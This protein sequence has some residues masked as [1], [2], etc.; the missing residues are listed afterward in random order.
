M[1]SSNEVHSSLGGTAW[2]YLWVVG[3]DFLRTQ[4]AS[5][6]FQRLTL[7]YLDLT[8]FHISL[9]CLWII[10]SIQVPLL[11]FSFPS[12]LW[13]DSRRHVPLPDPYAS[14]RHDIAVLD[15]MSL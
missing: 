12:S 10:D 1:M 15:C 9:R 3:V 8:R 7:A 6:I 2:D 5:S 13:C 14:Q 11:R 4:P